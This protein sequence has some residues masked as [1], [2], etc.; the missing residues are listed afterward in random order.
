MVR[1]GLGRG[2]GGVEI[3]R[4]E[5]EVD[6]VCKGRGFQEGQDGGGNEKSKGEGE[7]GF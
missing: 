1:A 2:S 7:E 4:A 5:G 6:G 3:L